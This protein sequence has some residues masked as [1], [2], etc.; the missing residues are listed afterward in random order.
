MQREGKIYAFEPNPASFNYLYE[1]TRD[2]SAISIYPL[3]VSDSS[4]PLTFFCVKRSNLSSALRQVGQPVV[5]SATTL[6]EFLDKRRLLAGADFVKCDVEG[7]ELAVMRGSR[8]LRRG[9][10]API[11]M[12][13]IDDG[14]LSDAGI[15]LEQVNTEVHAIDPSVHLFYLNNKGQPCR[16]RHIADRHAANIFIVPKHRLEQFEAA[17]A[18][19]TV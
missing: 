3:A 18:V 6:D 16:M 8:E 4:Q 10:H 7:G 12:I 13:E 1:N 2:Y 17:A 15:L 14:F 9:K 11:W 19:I 5:V